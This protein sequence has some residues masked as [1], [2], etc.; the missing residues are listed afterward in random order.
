MR[1]TQTTLVSLQSRSS[2]VAGHSGILTKNLE[3]TVTLTSQG[4]H[5]TNQLPGSSVITLIALDLTTPAHTTKATR[6]E[7]LHQGF[8]TLAHLTAETS[9]LG[10]AGPALAHLAETSTPGG[11]GTALAHLAPETSTPGGAGTA[12][13]HLVTKTSTPEG[14]GTNAQTNVVS[15][16]AETLFGT[17]KGGARIAPLHQATDVL[18]LQSTLVTQRIR[19]LIAMISDSPENGSR[20]VHQQTRR[21][22]PVLQPQPRRLQRPQQLLCV[23]HLLKRPSMDPRP[24]P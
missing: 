9:T 1:K 10:N 5:A 15:L 14:A 13:A 2:Q 19:G 17:E 24:Q 18:S 7:D 16:P 4:D 20:R 21:I 11:A 23:G 12:L 3:T 6:T 8:D 22:R